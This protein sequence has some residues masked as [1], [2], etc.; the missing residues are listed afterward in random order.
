MDLNGLYFSYLLIIHF[1]SS[2]HLHL[3]VLTVLLDTDCYMKNPVKPYSSYSRHQPVQ[4]K[5]LPLL[6]LPL[7]PQPLQ[8]VG[9]VH[10]LLRQLGTPLDP[11]RVSQSECLKVGQDSCTVDQ[12]TAER[13]ALDLHDCCK[14][15]EAQQMARG[16]HD[17]ETWCLFTK[18]ANHCSIRWERM[19]NVS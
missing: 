13:V 1:I 15:L 18:T 5:P 12:A 7:P 17:K 8:V 6:F 10:T 4:Y 14:R 16:L 19:G 11:A 9:W 2:I 3:D